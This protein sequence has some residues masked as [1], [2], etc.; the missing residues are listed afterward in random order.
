M[1]LAGGKRKATEP[2]R[3]EPGHVSF[4]GFTEV[5]RHDGFQALR[6]KN[7]P[8][9]APLAV[10]ADDILIVDPA[11]RKLPFVQ[12]TNQM[13]GK[14]IAQPRLGFSLGRKYM[15]S[16]K[17]RPV[18]PLQD[19]PAWYRDAYQRVLDAANAMVS[20][21]LNQCEVQLYVD[22]RH[23]IFPHSDN[24]KGFAT[25]EISVF[26]F[27]LGATRT[28]RFVPP[29]STKALATVDMEHGDAFIFRGD[30]QACRHEIRYTKD[31]DPPVGPRCSHSFRC[32][33]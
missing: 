20:R 9:G 3:A 8:G 21:P 17:A 27:V 18:T 19:L 22:G 14:T 24:E 1:A 6:C 32:M 2:E 25:C 33:V 13:M 11:E 26:I 28:M 30:Q 4:P 16:G 12:R 29:N 15:Y 7:W 5:F 10:V 31:S 23:G